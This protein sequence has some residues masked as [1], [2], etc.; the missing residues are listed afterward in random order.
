MITAFTVKNF[1]AIGDEPVRIELK[2]ITLLFGANSAGKS[3]I[4]HALHY[5]HEVFI[6]HNLN[7]QTSTIDDHNFIDLG[8]FER[9][10]Y[11][12]DL[13]RII[14]IRIDFDSHHDIEF[15]PESLF[16]R[17]LL[18]KQSFTL[19]GITNSYVEI[20]IAWNQIN[21]KPY[22]K[23]YETGLNGERMA[24]INFD[25]YKKQVI[26]EYL[27]I[28]HPLFHEVWVDKSINVGSLIK[29]TFDQSFYKI[30]SDIN[31]ESVK[32]NE[33]IKKE[34]KI[35][36]DKISNEQVEIIQWNDED[37]AYNKIIN[38]EIVEEKSYA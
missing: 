7:P 29:N 21:N 17:N 37:E 23:R 38:N 32:V 25:V 36:T 10:V 15:I 34:R 4:L 11:D 31:Q 27:N 18:F 30:S 6:N 3:S 16:I 26:L 20:D 22:V 28:D 5:A 8:G 33:I 24:T 13:N 35:I 1:K 12:R 9:F 19:D 2:P 14:F